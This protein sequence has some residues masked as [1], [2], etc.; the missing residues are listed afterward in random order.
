MRTVNFIH[1]LYPLF[2][3]NEF[4]FL[5]RR[6]RL[7]GLAEPNL[8]LVTSGVVAAGLLDFLEIRL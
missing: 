3:G 2:P 1:Q 5:N 8:L 6:I 7:K 4:S